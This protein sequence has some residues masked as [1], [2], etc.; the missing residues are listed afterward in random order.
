MRVRN[1][2]DGNRVIGKPLHHVGAPMREAQREP[3]RSVRQPELLHAG[4]QNGRVG[5]T[6]QNPRQREGEERLQQRGVDRE[7]RRKHVGVPGEERH[8]VRAGRDEGIAVGG[9]GGGFEVAVA[10]GMGAGR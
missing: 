10:G 1:S 8:G 2:E 9:D 3:D 5:G 6:A 4:Q 7:L